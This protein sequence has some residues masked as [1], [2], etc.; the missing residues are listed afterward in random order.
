MLIRILKGLVVAAIFS[1]IVAAQSQIVQI[2][3]STLDL[4]ATGVH[5][6]PL[7]DIGYTATVEAILGEDRA[8]MAPVL[9]YGVLVVN[10]SSKKLTA[11]AVTFRGLNA[12]G[13]K[14]RIDH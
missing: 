6:V 10:G 4:A 8:M 14:K 1:S 2:Q 7:D 9:P 13:Q 3:Q 11:I 5:L 12:E